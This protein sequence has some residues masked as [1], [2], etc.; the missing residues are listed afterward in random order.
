MTETTMAA[1]GRTQA[2]A[3]KYRPL[4]FGVTRGVLREGEGG[5]QYLAAETPLGP[6]AHR[7]TDRLVYWAAMAPAAPRPARGWRRA[8]GPGWRTTCGAC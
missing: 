3:P 4:A 1:A 7:M 5:V 2:A 8:A 6:H